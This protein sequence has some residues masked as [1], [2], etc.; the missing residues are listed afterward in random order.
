MICRVSL[1]MSDGRLP[2]VQS[3]QCFHDAAH[4]SVGTHYELQSRSKDEVAHAILIEHLD[5]L[6]RANS[7][8]PMSYRWLRPN[9]S[10]LAHF[11]FAWKDIGS[12][13]GS[14][15]VLRSS[16]PAS[17]NHCPDFPHDACWAQGLHRF[18][19]GDIKWMNGRQRYAGKADICVNGTYCKSGNPDCAMSE[20]IY[21]PLSG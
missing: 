10:M 8:T 17:A 7:L 6:Y 9:H 2:D 18:A 3:A 20:Y 5:A 13:N 15:L 16:N 14:L 12:Y 11:S 19:P 4:R 1:N 21:E